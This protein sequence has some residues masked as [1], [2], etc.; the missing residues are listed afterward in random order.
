[1]AV[2]AAVVIYS[3]ERGAGPGACRGCCTPRVRWA[4]LRCPPATA[5]AIELGRSAQA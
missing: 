3:G 5:S 1:M 2:G 4:S